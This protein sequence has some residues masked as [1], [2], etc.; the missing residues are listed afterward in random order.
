MAWVLCELMVRPHLLHQDENV[1]MASFVVRLICCMFL[2]RARKAVSSAYWKTCIL[3]GSGVDQ[4]QKV[5]RV[6]GKVPN[7][8]ELRNEGILDE[9]G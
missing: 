5:D 6:K 9:I 3:G 7:L 8:E 2:L 1:S 4:Q